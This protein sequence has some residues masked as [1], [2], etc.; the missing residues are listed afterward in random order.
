MG[1]PRAV[2]DRSIR[3]VGRDGLS[4]GGP[5]SRLAHLMIREDY[6]VPEND[7]EA[8]RWYRL[9][10]EQGDMTAQLELGYMYRNSRGVPED[11]VLAYMWYNLAATQEN[12]ARLARDPCGC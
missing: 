10:A 6:G 11:D 4:H 1:R 9:S 3:G 8:V 7:V 2:P 12:R 5:S